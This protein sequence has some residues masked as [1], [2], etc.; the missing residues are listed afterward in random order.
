M[1]PQPTPS[2]PRPSSTLPARARRVPEE[3]PEELLS[4]IHRCIDP[5]PSTRP[6]AQEVV[7]ALLLVADAP[8]CEEQAAAAARPRRKI[9]TGA[10]RSARTGLPS[11]L[12]AASPFLVARERQLAAAAAAAARQ[13]PEQ[14]QQAQQ[15][16]QQTGAPPFLAACQQPPAQQPPSQQPGASPS[17]AACERQ[18][19]QQQQPAQQPGASPFLAARERQQLQQQQPAQQPGASPFLAARERQLA[20]AQQPAGEPPPVPANGA[21]HGAGAAP[22]L[23]Q[24]QQQPVLL[25]PPARAGSGRPPRLGTPSLEAVLEERMIEEAVAELAG[26]GTA[27]YTVSHICSEGSGR[28]TPCPMSRSCSGGNGACGGGHGGACGGG[29]GGGSCGASAAG[30]PSSVQRRLLVPASPFASPFRPEGVAGQAQHSA[31]PGFDTGAPAAA[32]SGG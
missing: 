10:P 13:Q 26:P 21:S 19:L 27:S 11:A 28:L 24:Q 8:A 30:S 22:P 25:A 3:C 2:L 17:L 4:L 31:P 5:V 32:P 9:S 12:A 1:R 6:S 15:P 16:E 7:E 23:A 29:G 18:Q 20:A 14:A